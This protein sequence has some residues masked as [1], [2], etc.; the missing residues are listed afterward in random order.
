MIDDQQ[1]DALHFRRCG[2]AQDRLARAERSGA[3]EGPVLHAGFVG[4]RDDFERAFVLERF[5]A[6]PVL[7]FGDDLPRVFSAMRRLSA[8]DN[9][10]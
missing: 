4:G 2:E 10:R 8:R 7:R 9:K 3:L 1:R 6:R 5:R